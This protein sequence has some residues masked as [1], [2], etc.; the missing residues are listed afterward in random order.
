MTNKLELGGRPFQ[1]LGF[2]VEIDRK[3]RPWI[4]HIAHDP[5][6]RIHLSY[7]DLALA[8]GLSTIS[9][10]ISETDLYVNRKVVTDA[11][12]IAKKSRDALCE[13]ETLGCLTKI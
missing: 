4:T 9:A 3:L 7:G 12:R 2:N 1:V 5:M 10:K 13:I 11:I 6:M 8:S